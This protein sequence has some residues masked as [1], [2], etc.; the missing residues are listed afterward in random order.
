MIRF[1]KSVPCALILFHALLAMAL[2]A[3]R[4][5]ADPN[6]WEWSV[7][8]TMDHVKHEVVFSEAMQREVGYNIYL[9][10]S[11]FNEPHKRFSVVYWLHGAGGD[12]K[13]SAYT[14]EI[15]LPEIEAG[16]VPEAIYV[17][18]NGGHWSSYRD[19][20]TSYVKSETHLIHELIPEIDKRYRTINRRSGRAIFGFS[21][22]GGGS[23]RLG[24]KY[25]DLFCAIGSFSGAMAY[26]RDPETREISTVQKVYPEDN[27]YL[28]ATKHQDQWKDKVR[29]FLTVGGCEWLYDNH[30]DF[31]A[32]LMSLGI[33]FDLDVRG[34]LT[35]NLGT[36]KKLFGSEMVR[37]LGSH[38]EAPVDETSIPRV[39]EITSDFW[40][41]CT[42]P[43]L[44][45]LNGPNPE[46]QH[47]VDHG[48]MM[49]DNGKWQLWACMR[50]T[51]VSRLLYGWEGTSLEKGPWRELGV[52]A[53][54]DEKYGE[55]IR[56]V[57]G[58]R[59]ETMGAPFFYKEGNHYYCFYH[60]AGIR[61]MDSDDGI[62]YRRSVNYSGSNLLYPDGGRDVMVLNIDGV[63]HAYST[64]TERN[65]KD[66]LISYVKLKTSTDM[67]NWG[68]P[69][70][71]CM[72]GKDGTGAVA[73]ESP[74]VVYLDGYY[75]L[76][77]ASSTTFKTYV[78]R[79]E[80]PTYF[81][82]NDDSNLIAEFEIKAPE[83]FQ[84]DGQWYI[85]DLSD[86]QG[87]KL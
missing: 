77:R 4:D 10:P 17:F 48:F 45:E 64:I 32:H 19:S 36:S 66:E 46:K 28:W 50:G 62:H 80:D 8:D 69:K 34:A 51:A 79:S 78:Y 12:E 65:A 31:L 83:V 52:V 39:P 59:T 44:G 24:L 53:R 3:E 30:P 84:H 16:T 74:Y 20:E 18:V 76:F 25:P 55:Q 37:F 82:V 49:A 6:T 29:I 1:F 70:I 60:S 81:G 21:M 47:I 41:I 14:M 67:R 11:Y 2:H 27:I 42:M 68:N 57:D 73:F 86:F 61:L 87:I 72:G 38:Y 9:P 23:M 35:H 85:S 63:Y 15:I 58:Q 13:T 71:V 22:G 43:D 5:R 7:P 54:A 33:K 26:A 40:R 56:E 75:Y